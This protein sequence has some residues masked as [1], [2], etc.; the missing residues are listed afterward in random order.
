VADA[1]QVGF[2]IV[3]GVQVRCAESTGTSASSILLTSRWPE[4]VYA[5]AP[6]W[7]SLGERRSLGGRGPS[8]LRTIRPPAASRPGLLS[9]VV[10]GS[11]GSAVP[12][13]LSGPLAEWMLA[14]EYASLIADW[15]ADGY[16]VAAAGGP[17]AA[18]M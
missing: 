14:P 6:I 1:M 3:D 18:V 7:P 17:T 9:S 8:G 13:Q 2:R 5:F 4:S 11:G 16:R 15:V 12:I 10:V